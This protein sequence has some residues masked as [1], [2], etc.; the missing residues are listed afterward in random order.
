MLQTT[1]TL[2]IVSSQPAVGG[3]V[4]AGLRREIDAM[5]LRIARIATV[6]GRLITAAEMVIVA[7][8]ALTGLAVY[9]LRQR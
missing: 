5:D 7:G 2:E 3:T 4:L 1:S 9:P 8:A 6:S